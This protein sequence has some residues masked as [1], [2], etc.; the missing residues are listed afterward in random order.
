MI[1]QI[2]FRLGARSRGFHLVT[3]EIL[4]NL[5]SLPRVGLLNLFIQ[6]TSA[7]LTINEKVEVIGYTSFRESIANAAIEIKEGDKTMGIDM[8]EALQSMTN[9]PWKYEVD[10][11]FNAENGELNKIYDI[12]GL[13]LFILIS[14]DGKIIDRGFKTFYN[15][16]LKVI[17]SPE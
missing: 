12:K 2:E 9:H 17:E 6:H 14:P 11:D 10:A 15:G 1:N 3:D 13:P 16:S 7:G 8:Y 5:P 4:R